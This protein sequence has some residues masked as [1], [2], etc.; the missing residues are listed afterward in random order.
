MGS[1]SRSSS[2][3]ISLRLQADVLCSQCGENV[4]QYRVSLGMDYGD[5]FFQSL[6]E[7]KEAGF[8]QKFFSRILYSGDLY[9]ISQAR[10]VIEGSSD[11]LIVL[12][13]PGLPTLTLACQL[14]VVGGQARRC[15]NFWQI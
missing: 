1:F 5:D 2:S 14:R 8:V 6:S 10:S 3:S 11:E 9:L 13:R 15:L 12:A 4:E 7:G